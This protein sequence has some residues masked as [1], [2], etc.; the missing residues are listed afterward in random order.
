MT[1]TCVK[2][3]KTGLYSPLFLDYLAKKPALKTYYNEY[4]E[5]AGF[6]KLLDQKVFSA[7]QR[8]TLV[9][10][11]TQQYGLLYPEVEAQIK[12]LGHEKTFTVTT[13]HQLNLMTGPLYFIYKIVTTINLAEKLK[14]AYPECHFVP[15]YWMATED[16]D[17]EEINYFKLDGKKYQWESNQTGAVGDFE[18][19]KSFQKWLGS[20]GFVPSFFQDAYSSSKKLSEAVRKYVHHLFG[21]RGLLVVDGHDPIL[22]KAVIPIL[23]SDLV[24]HAPFGLVSQQTA[25]LE[26]LGY[27]SQIYPREIN[28]FY[29]EKGLRER[30]ERK[31]DTFVVL[32]TDLE[33]SLAQIQEMIQVY[34]ERFSPNVVLRPLYQELILPNLAYIGGPAEVAYWLQLK[35]VFDHFE[36]IFPAVMPR[37]FAMVIDKPILRKMRQVGLR[38]EGLFESVQDW[39][40]KHLQLH[41]TLDLEFSNERRELNKV[42]ED[43]K[44]GAIKVDLSL[45]KAYEAAKVRSAKLLDHL[46]SKVRKAE[47]KRHAMTI[48]QRQEIQDALFPG[49]SPQERV[50]N[51][52]A[53]YLG[54][55]NFVTA[56]FAQ[57]DPFDFDFIVLEVDEQD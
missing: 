36:V 28:C 7:A 37:N 2:S 29:L 1:K 30:I 31:G 25:N 48:R 42:F 41:S 49:G 38:P 39:K 20:L 22:K 21:E 54:N 27:K 4:P 35:P 13:G 43:A 33:F 56:L 19:D 23:Q 45:E 26:S 10:A 3:D 50:E 32:N 51:F 46:S 5:A 52:L 14:L 18:L 44:Q 11:L 40:K 55:E 15:V 57:F 47:E 9:E 12:S 53:F 17:F 24:E 34:P 8:S 6:Q 16:H